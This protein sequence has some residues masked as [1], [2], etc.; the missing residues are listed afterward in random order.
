M[1]D[2]HFNKL[3]PA[4]SERLALLI[5][6]M[7]ETQQIACKILRHG[8]ASYNPDE[9]GPTNRGLLEKEIGHAQAAISMMQSA[10]DII[11]N[12]VEHYKDKKLESVK[13][14]LHHQEDR[15]AFDQK[16]GGDDD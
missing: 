2:K 7:A 10:G 15:A 13:Q 6:E 5:E 11:A 9:C 16:E 3:S 4:E 8:Y 1:M 12:T 14:W